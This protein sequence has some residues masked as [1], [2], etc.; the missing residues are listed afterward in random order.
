MA[1]RERPFRVG[2]FA[3][4]WLPEY[5][6]SSALAPVRRTA[7]RSATEELQRTMMNVAHDPMPQ[8]NAMSK[9]PLRIRER[10]PQTQH[11]NGRAH[12]W[13]RRFRSLVL[14][15]VPE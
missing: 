13:L 4:L 1:G 7:N 6:F 14:R 3:R 10:K 8:M 12:S 11:K 15:L 2:A 5:A 9:R